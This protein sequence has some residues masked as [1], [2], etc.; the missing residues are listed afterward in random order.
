FML[1]D[2]PA[3]LVAR[4]KELFAGLG[5]AAHHYSEIRALVDMVPESTMLMT[6]EQVRTGM[7]GSWRAL[8][9]A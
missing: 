1:L 4:R 6:P 2:P 5:D 9:G 3:D 7:P 8:T